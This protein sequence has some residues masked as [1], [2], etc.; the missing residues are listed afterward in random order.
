MKLLKNSLKI[1]SFSSLVAG[2]LISVNVDSASA[3]VT[4]YTDLSSWDAAAGSSTLEEFN[5]DTTFI[6]GTP[7]NFNQF[8]ITATF[9]DT[10]ESVAVSG[11]ELTWS[12]DNISPAPVI[13]INFDNPTTGFAFNWKDDDATNSYTL[14]VDG[15]SFS[16]P[17]FDNTTN[18]NVTDFFGVVSDTPFS[19]VTFTNN[20]PSGPVVSSFSLDNA[21]TSA[22]VP[23]EFSP[24]LGF[25]VIGGL[26]GANHLRKRNSKSVVLDSGDK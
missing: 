22:A 3:I 7:E 25:L 11:G 6:G 21:R 24:T 26:V 1:L 16:N 18:I 17:P 5:D 4:T 9:N 13:E 12:G 19:S 14:N 20:S 10:T 2:S 15:E 8:D 23:F